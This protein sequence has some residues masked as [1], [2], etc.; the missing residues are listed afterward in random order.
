MNIVIFIQLVSF[1]NIHVKMNAESSA[2]KMKIY[3][4][5]NAKNQWT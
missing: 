1:L 2:I 5:T 3:A 4:R